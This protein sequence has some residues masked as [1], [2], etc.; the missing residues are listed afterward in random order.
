MA[1]S[2]ASSEVRFH[3]PVKHFGSETLCD[4]GSGRGPARPQRRRYDNGGN[5][6]EWTASL[7]RTI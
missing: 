1:F 5:S 7:E 4:S 3:K 2:L 6:N